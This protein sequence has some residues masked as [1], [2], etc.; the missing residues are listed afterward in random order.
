MQSVVQELGW[1]S[2][3]CRAM[4]HRKHGAPCGIAESFPAHY[5]GLRVPFPRETR[6]RG[7]VSA[8]SHPSSGDEYRRS[9]RASLFRG[10]DIPDLSFTGGDLIYPH[11][12]RN[13][14]VRHSYG[15]LEIGCKCK[16]P[17]TRSRD[18]PSIPDSWPIPRGNL[19]AKPCQYAHGKIPLARPPM[20]PDLPASPHRAV[21]T[22]F[23]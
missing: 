17:A 1:R 12:E 11:V 10:L 22:S 23:Q 8:V 18:N 5:G 9:G 4:V 19:T 13:A 14:V 6:G 7:G 16:R 2:L 21:V 3:P 20:T 15:V